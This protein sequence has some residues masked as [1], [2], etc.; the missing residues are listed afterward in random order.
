MAKTKT[1]M[2]T[3][4]KTKTKTAIKREKRDARIS[5]SEREQVRPQVKTAEEK[6]L[7]LTSEGIFREFEKAVPKGA[8]TVHVLEAAAM[9]I[10]NSLVQM[11]G[12]KVEL[13]AVFMR[14]EEWVLSKVEVK[15]DD[16]EK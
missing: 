16:N 4:T 15:K 12:T 7:A 6:A 14:L 1:T 10:G 9:L 5:T 13:H 2:A 11:G 8:T 3:K